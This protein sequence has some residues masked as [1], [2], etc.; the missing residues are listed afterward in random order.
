MKI[1]HT[2]PNVGRIEYEI[3]DAALAA[4]IYPLILAMLE[5]DYVLTP[6]EE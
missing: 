1:V 3:E 5:E 2:C 4:S 6:K